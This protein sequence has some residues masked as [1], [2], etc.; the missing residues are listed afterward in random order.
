MDKSLFIN[1]GG[2]GNS[3]HELEVITNNL[4]NANTPGFRSDTIF[5]EKYQQASG[6]QSRI[7]ARMAGTYSDFNQGPII[8]TERDLDVAINGKGFIA[9]Q[10]KEGKEGYTREGSLRVNADGVLTT[11]EDQLVLGAGGPITIPPATKMHIS[12]DGSI[13]IIPPGATALV[14]IDQIK[15]VNPGEKTISKGKDGLFY[16]NDG[17]AIQSSQDVEI[18]T[19]AIEGSNVSVIDAMTRLIELSRNYQTHTNFIKTISEDTT[20]SNQ[21]LEVP[22]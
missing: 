12:S 21:I 17:N 18:I 14:K 5:N 22:K 3:M 19:G 4:A 10:S 11:S 7:Y 16:S 15:F 20:K 8:K 2:A 1:M 9:V 6:D 13:S